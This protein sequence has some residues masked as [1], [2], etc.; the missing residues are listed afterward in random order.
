MPGA[1]TA[2]IGWYRAGA[3]A[4]AR[5]LAESPP[6]PE[7]RITV[8]TTV[9]WP[10]HDPLFPREW[11]DRVGEFFAEAELRHVDGAG[12]FTPLECADGFAEAL[13]AAAAAPR[14]A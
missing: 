3:G 11:S 9:L 14:S 2:S 4:V 6:R 10:E 7:D 12:H 13:A 5:S 8:P 1:F